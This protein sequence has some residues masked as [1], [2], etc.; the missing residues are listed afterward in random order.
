MCKN[1]TVNGVFRDGGFSEYCLLRPEAVVDIPAEADPA[2]L[3]P[4]L[5]AG[6]TVFNSLRHQKLMPGSTVAV[7]GKHTPPL[8]SRRFL[9]SIEVSA[10]LDI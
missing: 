9:T 6:V 7:Q 2:A 4:Q 5:C 8:L 1:G 3:A 10:V